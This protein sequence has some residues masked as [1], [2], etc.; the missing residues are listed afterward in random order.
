[1][2]KTE[3]KYFIYDH[4]ICYNLNYFIKNLLRLPFECLYKLCLAVCHIGKIENK[5]FK[6]AICAIFKNEAAY[7]KEWIEYHKIVGIDHFYLYNN[8]SEDNYKDVL[9]PYIDCGLVSLIQWPQNQAQMQAYCDGIDKFGREAEWLTFIDIDEFIVPNTTD[10]VYDF[11]KPFQKKRPVVIA[12]WKMFGTS[13]KIS[14]SISDLVTEDLY[15]CWNK[16]TDIGK[17]FFNTAYVFDKDDSRNKVL[18][19]YAWGKFG[20]V[21]IPPVN[22]FDK[23]CV[24]G[25]NP[26][27]KSVM[28]DYF[29]LQINHYFTKT[30]N[31]YL[32]KCAK[33]D[34][35]FKI[36]PHTENYFYE[37]E[38]KNKSTD[39]H[40]YKYI[41]KLKLA[42][43]IKE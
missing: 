4:P 34:V 22:V 39:F 27:P 36:N 19:H 8:N 2:I 9:Q 7:L 16:Y 13:G 20:V 42:M 23:V 10:T 18:H 32:K 17:I 29:P 35:Y 6:V 25:K 43:G 40:I 30:Y 12:Y 21:P 24:F 33:G 38:M 26:V 1:M 15:I 3:N 11:L 14:R 5:K 37:H 31:E 41:I 28:Y